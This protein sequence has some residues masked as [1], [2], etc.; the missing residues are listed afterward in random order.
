MIWIINI[1]LSFLTPFEHDSGLS[2]KFVDI[3]VR[4]MIPAFIFDVVSTLTLVTNYQ[5]ERLYYLKFLR[6]YYFPRAMDILYRVIDPVV[7]RCNIS[8]QA[9][10][11]VQSIFS[12]FI[13]LFTIMHMVACGWIYVGQ[14][15]GWGTWLV[16]FDIKPD[17]TTIYITS[18]YWV[19]TTLTTVGYGDIFGST[20]EE[21]IYTMIVEFIGILVF[22][23]IMGTVN[24]FLSAQGDIDIV[25]AKKDQVD[26]WL[27]KLDNSRM[28]KSLP[29]IL[30][31]KIKHYIEESLT[32][33]HKKLIDGYEFLIQLKPRLRYELIKELFEPMIRDFDHMFKYEDDQG[34]VI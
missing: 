14:R 26:V 2:D 19:V 25:E 3:A 21:Y 15:E 20:K 23:I 28:S 29:K 34:R 16:N 18:L 33:D 5:Y 6:A 31:D 9:R 22:S 32:H 10:S 4:Y 13:I 27:V 1:T 12:Q 8:K 17:G 11:N 30:Y 24:T 7:T